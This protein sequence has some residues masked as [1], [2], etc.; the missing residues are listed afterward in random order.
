MGLAP[1]P[2]S[3]L[4]VE[5]IGTKRTAALVIGCLHDEGGGAGDDYTDIRGRSKVGI[6]Q[7]TI[8][9]VLRKVRFHSQKGV[10]SI[11]G[12]LG[13][14]GCVPV[15]GELGDRHGGQDAQD[16]NHH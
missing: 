15:L 14:V 7:R 8:G 9:E 5:S 16:G 12:D 11:G 1:L 4:L 13:A 3:S 2:S 6:R 10:R